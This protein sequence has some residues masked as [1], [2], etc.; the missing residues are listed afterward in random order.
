MKARFEKLVRG[1]SLSEDLGTLINNP[2]YSDLEIKC[3]D[4]I[5]LHANRAILAVRS[6]FFN[7]MLFNKMK[8]TYD[9]QISFP[10]IDASNMKIILEY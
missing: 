7:C 1:E 4:E 5:V 2:H 10:N 6:E 3:K 9:T 8:E